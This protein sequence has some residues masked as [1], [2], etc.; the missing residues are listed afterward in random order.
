MKTNRFEISWQRWKYFPNAKKGVSYR[1]VGSSREF[2]I[3][4]RWVSISVY[5]VD[6][7]W[8]LL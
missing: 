1:R 6:K 3:N 4:T 7:G 5:I 2:V 8:K